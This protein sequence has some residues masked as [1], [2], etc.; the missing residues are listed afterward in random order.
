MNLVKVDNP[1]K[2]Q[3]L[4]C[5]RCGKWAHV[6]E[7]LADLAG[8]PFQAYYCFACLVYLLGYVKARAAFE[9]KP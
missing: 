7:V 5:C 8:V 1:R 6:E 9:V 4:L 2:G 3:Q